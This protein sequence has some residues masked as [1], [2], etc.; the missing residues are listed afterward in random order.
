V[1]RRLHEAIAGV[2]GFEGVDFPEKRFGDGAL[3][4]KESAMSEALAAIWLLQHGDKPQV[5][6]DRLTGG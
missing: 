1:R 4:R 2:S 5:L 3:S 6:F